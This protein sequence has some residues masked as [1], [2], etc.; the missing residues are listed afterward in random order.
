V[1]ALI[2]DDEPLARLRLRT[3]LADHGDVSVIG[4]CADAIEAVRA[5]EREPPD[6]V[7]LDVQMP[8]VD[9]FALL[10]SLPIAPAPRVVFTTAHA[11]HAVRAFD[12]NAV[13][14]LL[15][16]FDDVRLAVTLERTRSR[17]AAGGTDPGS[18]PH[19]LAAYEI[20]SLLGSGAAGQVYKARDRRLE[21]TV[22]LKFLAPGLSG[23]PELGRRFLQEAK[24]AAALD[25]PNVCTLLGVERSEDGRPYLVMPFYE[26][27]TLKA[28]IARGPLPVETARGYARQIV[29]GLAHAH[30]AGVIHRDIK[31]ANVLV[32][33]RGI[34]KILDF[35]V[36]KISAVEQT[37][38]GLLLGTPAYMSP[39]QAAGEPVDRSADLWG[40][41]AVLYEMLTGRPPFGTP[42]DL[43]TLLCAIQV[44]EPVPVRVLRPEVPR[45]LARVVHRLLTKEP[46]LRPRDANLMEMLTW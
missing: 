29:A 45:R 3:M 12:V 21:R 28:A 41:G 36:A 17:L 23:E 11:A 37:R 46:G 25:H 40:L 31:P 43:L 22:A 26:G 7:F 13:D 8:Q 6:V 20:E 4:E 35:G 9:G 1:N 33:E 10:R 27:E 30:A 34:L 42:D 5:I 24:A 16:P 44:R 39:E 14:F 15:K 19:R 2:V 38:A 32:T 18:A